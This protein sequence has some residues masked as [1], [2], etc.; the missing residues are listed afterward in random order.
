MG[1]RSFSAGARELGVSRSAVSQAV[2]QLEQQLRVVLRFS[3]AAQALS[4]ATRCYPA[5]LRDDPANRWHSQ[6]TM[7]SMPSWSGTFTRSSYE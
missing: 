3:G 4:D 1:L 2:Q 6:T 7:R 5:D